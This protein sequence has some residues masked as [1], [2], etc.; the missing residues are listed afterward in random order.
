MWRRLARFL[1]RTLLRVLPAEPP[2]ARHKRPVAVAGGAMRSGGTPKSLPQPRRQEVLALT[3]AGERLQFASVA[4]LLRASRRAD[5]VVAVCLDNCAWRDF[6]DFRDGV[7]RGMPALAAFEQSRFYVGDE[8]A[9]RLTCARPGS[10][11]LPQRVA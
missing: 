8:G 11:A 5:R 1:M 6:A 9:V 3:V 2:G 4:T 10:G 7:W